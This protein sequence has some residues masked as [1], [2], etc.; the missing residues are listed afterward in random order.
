MS[1]LVHLKNIHMVSRSSSRRQS[2]QA[3][4]FAIDIGSSLTNISLSL[5]S[6]LA[7]TPQ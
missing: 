2:C 6:I 7:V 1:L 4:G 5:I 3:K